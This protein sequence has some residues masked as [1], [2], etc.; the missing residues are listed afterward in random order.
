VEKTYTDGR[1]LWPPVPAE[2]V[3][4]LREVARQEGWK[5]GH[6]VNTIKRLQETKRVYQRRMA[7]LPDYHPDINLLRSD[8][9]RIERELVR[10]KP[11]TPVSSKNPREV[12]SRRPGQDV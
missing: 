4:L 5:T 12:G 10:V 6:A 9:R 1:E 3:G 7:E 2:F 11:N 8:I